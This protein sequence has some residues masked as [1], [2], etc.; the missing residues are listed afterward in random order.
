MNTIW[1]VYNS[2]ILLNIN[3]RQLE[4]LSLVQIPEIQQAAIKMIITH[5]DY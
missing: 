4:C 1:N 3:K 5:S 2:F